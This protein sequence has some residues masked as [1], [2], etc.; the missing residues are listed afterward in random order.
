MLDET[1]RTILSLW[2]ACRGNEMSS[3]H[4]PFDGGYAQQP[5]G[6]IACFNEMSVAAGLINERMPQRG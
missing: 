3:G 1:E 5:A 6:L 2:L 4:L